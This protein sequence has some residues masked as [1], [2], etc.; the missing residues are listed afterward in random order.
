MF[1][2]CERVMD[3]VGEGEKGAGRRVN[4]MR[5]M[6]VEKWEDGKEGK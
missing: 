4:V 6:K 2:E 1:Y 5:G 3:S